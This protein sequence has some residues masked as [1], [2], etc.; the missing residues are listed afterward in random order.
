M[1]SRTGILLQIEQID[2]VISSTLEDITHEMD[3]LNKHLTEIAELQNKIDHQKSRR[4][5]AEILLAKEEGR[6]FQ[7]LLYKLRFK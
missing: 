5:E 7:L 2:S 1:S 3:Y 4:R 6:W